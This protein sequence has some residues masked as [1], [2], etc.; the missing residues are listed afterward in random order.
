MNLT[1]RQFG[2]LLGTIGIGAFSGC[3]D[4][5]EPD[6]Q[7]QRTVTIE[8]DTFSPEDLKASTGEQVEI[9]FENRDENEHTIT[10][11]NVDDSNVTV[12]PGETVCSTV[13]VPAEPGKYDIEMEGTNATLALES[14]PESLQGGCGD[15]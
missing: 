14:V 6:E 7:T 15:E 2:T 10:M 1:R 11:A 4:S 13:S 9:T 5:A 12:P 3:L 8:N